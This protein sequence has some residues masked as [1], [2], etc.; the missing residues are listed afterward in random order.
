VS[1]P[2]SETIKESGVELPPSM[3]TATVINVQAAGSGKV[4]A[5]GDFVMTAEEVNRVAGALTK[6]GI[7]ITALHNHLLHA[8][9][10]VYFMHFW[11]HEAPDHVAQGL[12]AALDAMMTVRPRQPIQFAQMVVATISPAR[13]L[14]NKISVCIESTRAFG[15]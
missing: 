14:S 10:N 11:A 7:Q 4:A 12:R 2:R 9:P 3:G 8:A 13:I 5:T 15:R 6:H 1:V